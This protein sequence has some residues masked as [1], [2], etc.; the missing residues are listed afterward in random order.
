[1]TDNLARLGRLEESI[2]VLTKKHIALIDE[3]IDGH[4]VHVNRTWI[5]A[6]SSCCN[7]ATWGWFVA[8]IE[9]IGRFSWHNTA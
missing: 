8:L 4:F 3:P 6:T 1:M 5:L 9:I 2:E 7:M